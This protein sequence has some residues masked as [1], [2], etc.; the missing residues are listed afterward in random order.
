MADRDNGMRDVAGADRGQ[1]GSGSGNTG[2]DNGMRDVAGA[3]RG[4]PDALDRAIANLGKPGAGYT[5]PHGL[6]PHLDQNGEM[7]PGSM[8]PAAL[9]AAA[10]YSRQNR[11]HKIGV[12]V[13]LWR[14]R[15]L[16]C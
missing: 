16:P 15:R 13:R 12:R 6:G 2:R 9:N 4:Q 5:G 1:A 7:V 3:D 14:V 8:E 11:G 10:E